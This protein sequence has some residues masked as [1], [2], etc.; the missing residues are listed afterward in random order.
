MRISVSGVCPSLLT[1]VHPSVCQLV[2]KYKS[3]AKLS[4]NAA[5]VTIQYTAKYSCSFE[6]FSNCPSL[7]NRSGSRAGQLGPRASQP[8]PKAIQ[9]GPRGSR[10]CPRASQPGTW[11]SKP[12]T[13]A[14][15]TSPRCSKQGRGP[16][17][18]PS[19]RSI[20]RENR[21]KINPFQRTLSPMG[22]AAP[23]QSNYN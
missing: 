12:G 2:A 22:I 20:G 10:P 6:R 11:A 17:S 9:S 8:G 14:R 21:Q 16:T 15:Q 4:K 23:Q 19:L 5:S 7:A 3:E 13:R 18:Q 1:L